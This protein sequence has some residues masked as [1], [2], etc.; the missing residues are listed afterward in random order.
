MKTLR[1]EYWKDWP[2][3]VP[4][5]PFLEEYGF[6]RVVEGRL[7][8]KYGQRNDRCDRV[9]IVG[10]GVGAGECW[11]EVGYLGKTVKLILPPEEKELPTV[12][13]LVRRLGF[14]RSR[15][16]KFEQ[17]LREIACAPGDLRRIAREALDD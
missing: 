1:D 7:T 2:I 4:D 11:T 13:D 17:A 5:G 8:T 6:Y 3:R 12:I 14:E 10:K 9:V 16:N 15:A